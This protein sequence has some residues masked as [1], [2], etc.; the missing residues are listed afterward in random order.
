M[1]DQVAAG[2]L[3]LGGGTRVRKSG[4]SLV[5]L[6]ELGGSEVDLTNYY[7]KGE[8][9]IRLAFKQHLLDNRSGTGSTLL[10]SNLIRRLRGGDGVTVSED[11]DGNLLIA[12]T[13][14]S[15][16]GIPA[17]IATFESSLIELKVPASCHLGLD[18]TGVS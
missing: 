16:S 9:D 7:N 18:V 3:I 12:S 11:A 13:G 8:V 1:E 6:E 15:S 4:A 17:S 10:A 2:L 14:G 5:R